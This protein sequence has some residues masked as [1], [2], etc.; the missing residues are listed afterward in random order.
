MQHIILKIKAEITAADRKLLRQFC[1][2]CERLFATKIVSEGIGIS[3]S[4][5][6]AIDSGLAFQ[7]VLPDESLIVELLAAYRFFHLQKEPTH[8]SKMLDLMRRYAQN[9]EARHGI[10]LLSN[11]WHDGLL[12][13]ALDFSLNGERVTS[14]RLLDLWL[15][16]YY[17]HTDKRKEP[18]LVQL[19]QSF[20]SDFSKYLLLHS[21][22]ERTK[23]LQVL[24]EPIKSGIDE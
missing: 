10:N 19:N 7:A 4:T 18:H 16:A 21:V 22:Y 24:Y 8:F 20:T 13:R 12:K 23:L 1:D 2:K 9:H 11:S 15:N 6:W 14:A 17:F 5:N 3:G